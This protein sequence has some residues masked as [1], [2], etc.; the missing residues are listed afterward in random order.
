MPVRRLQLAL[1]AFVA[2]A[3]S[4]CG[5]KGAV[6]LTVSVENPTLTVQQAAL[7]TG[8]A[9]GFDL[10]LE[11]GEYADESTSVSLGTFGIA[12]DGSELVPTLELTPQAGVSFPVSVAPGKSRRVSLALSGTQ[13]YDSAVGTQICAGSVAY[14]G[15][16]TDSLNDGKSTPAS[17]NAFTPSCP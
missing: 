2:F 17:S 7:G 11:L 4:A 16:V 5:S 10:V 12:Q 14:R 15:G 6:S 3:A 8:L 13:T 1:V 9:G